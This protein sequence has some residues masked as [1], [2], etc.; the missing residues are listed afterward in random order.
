MIIMLEAIIIAV[1]LESFDDLSQDFLWSSLLLTQ[2]LNFGRT[3]DFVMSSQ[4]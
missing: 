3:I 1:S 4:H 2:L